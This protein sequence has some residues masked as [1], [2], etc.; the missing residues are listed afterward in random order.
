MVCRNKRIYY[1]IKII[2]LRHAHNS[3]HVT[4]DLIFTDQN[5]FD[6]EKKRLAYM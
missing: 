1:N 3:T 6:S 4:D 2:T 5:L